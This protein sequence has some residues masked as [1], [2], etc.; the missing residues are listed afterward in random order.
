MPC[1]ASSADS[2]VH[3]FID[4]V[5]AKD[6]YL[7]VAVIASLVAYKIYRKKF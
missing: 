6:I 7:C 4:N 3:M 2:L 1:V 5:C